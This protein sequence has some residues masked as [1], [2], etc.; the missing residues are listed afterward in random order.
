VGGDGWRLVTTVEE[1]L[2]VA[3]AVE[4]TSLVGIDLETTG[5][6]P[7]TDR[8]RLI[9]LACDTTDGGQFLYLVDCFAVDPRPLFEPLAGVS[10]VNHNIGFDLGFLF[11]MGFEPGG[12]VDDLMLMSQLLHAGRIGERHSL[13]AIAKRELDI[14]LDKAEQKADWSAPLTP[15]RLE[16]AAADVAHLHALYAKLKAQVD[17]AGLSRVAEIEHRCLPAWVWMAAQGVAVDR[18]AWLVLATEAEGATAALRQQLD[19][20]APAQPGSLPGLGGWN[21]NSNDDVKDVLGLLGCAVESTDDDTLASLNLPLAALLREYRSLSKRIGTYGRAWLETV[22]E[23]GRVYGGW[24]QLGSVAGRT[25][26]QEPNLQQIPRDAR[27]RACFV[28]PPG[29]ILVKADYSQIQLRIAAKIA[30]ERR[31]LDAYAQGEDLHT[32]TARQIL[33]KQQ[34][35]KA[36]RQLAKAIN[37]G[38]LFGL[39]VKGFRAYA[40]TH[41]GLELSEEQAAAYRLAFFDAYPGLARWHR[42]AGRKGATECRTLA[43]RR[44]LLDE[45]TPYTHRL[46]T[47]VQGTEA[48]GLKR[49]LA[50]LWQRRGECPGAAPVL[51]VH[52]EVVVECER[53]QA[54]AVAAWLKTALVDGMAPLIDPVPVEVETSVGH[55]WGGD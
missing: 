15:A 42:Q 28:A 9:S 34:V 14:D 1:V 32:L 13:K 55:T 33:G 17:A 38:L 22:A 5:L 3:R 6:N 21:W 16:Y 54:E 18:E 41:Y 37:F 25:S 51:V 24:R 40:W 50:L 12:R 23:D 29:R 46:N 20:A 19:A 35:S 26:C 4:E 53:E 10:L 39:G 31:M 7:R 2:T 27:Y 30:G 48:D 49:A 47:P 8:V 36:D 52:D 45:K 43:G 11:Q 44:R